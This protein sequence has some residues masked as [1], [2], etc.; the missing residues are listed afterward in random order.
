MSWQPSTFTRAQMAERRRA[1]GRLLQRGT[2]RQAAIARRL[3]VSEA[4]VSKW[5][6]QLQRAGLRGLW[7]R[8]ACGRPAV[9][10]P[11]QHHAIRA[12]LRRG[13]VAFGFE[14]ERWTLGR[15]RTV[16]GRTQGVWYS[17]VHI[18]RLLRRWGW[19]LQ[20][21]AGQ[22]RERDDAQITAWRH[23]DWPRIKKKPAG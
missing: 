18:R 5:A 15:I 12:V 17:L 22:A 6:K 20:Q 21:P 19:S 11:T 13:A 16:I 3:G 14:T 10:N 7:A 4:A 2:L 8:Q 1:G 23:H 9:L